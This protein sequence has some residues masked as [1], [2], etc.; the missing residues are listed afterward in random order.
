[1]SIKELKEACEDLHKP[2]AGYIDPDPFGVIQDEINK[3][4]ADAN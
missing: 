2:F 4:N 1:M 3:D